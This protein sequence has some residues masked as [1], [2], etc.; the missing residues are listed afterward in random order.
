MPDRIAEFCE[1]L[2][3]GR[4]RCDLCPHHCVVEPGQRGECLTRTN[5][6]GRL[7]VDTYGRLRAASVDPVEKKPL[8][9]FR[10][11]ST[12]FSIASTGC[13]MVCPF[14][15]NYR[16][17][18]SLRLGQVEAAAG[19]PHTPEEVVE[20]ARRSGSR[21]ISFTYSEPVL[22]YELAK[23]VADLAS[24]LDLLF[25]TNGQVTTRPG[26]ELAGFLAAAN[27][28]L[29]S[30]RAASYRDVLGGSLKATLR[31]LESFLEGGVWT[32]VTTLVVPGFNDS[33]E[34]LAE[35]ARRVADLGAFV[36][37]HVSRF[38][39]DYRWLERG[40]TPPE[41]LARARE[42]GHAEGLDYVYVGNLPGGEGEKTFCPSCRSVVVD[43]RGYRVLK[44]DTENGCCATC[45]H[46]I[47]G[48]G[49]P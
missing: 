24:G 48:T 19:R 3:E 46:E 40:P 21:S 20:E 47:A 38:H 14:C 22:M 7:V 35:I 18:Q 36:P 2:P 12:T 44:I 4:V 42:I 33:D 15:Q 5:Q 28:D 9:H 16:L 17:S 27:V 31:T 25:V 45:D 43:R 26:K 41:T 39:P 11:G 1:E 30:S 23:D 34:E 13:N 32:E 49:L 37:W 8:F 29:K 10:P 6:G